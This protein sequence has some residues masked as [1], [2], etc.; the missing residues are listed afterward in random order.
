MVVM[1]DNTH[2]I[3]PHNIF[4]CVNPL[5]F[6]VAGYDSLN[7]K[8]SLLIRDFQPEV[9]VHVKNE[10]KHFNDAHME[11]L[12]G[13]FN[14]HGVKV[15]DCE[16]VHRRLFYGGKTAAFFKI[17]VKCGFH[18]IKYIDKQPPF[19]CS[20]VH[21][22]IDEK[23][24]LV[25]KQGIS[26]CDW[27]SYDPDYT[28]VRNGIHFSVVPHATLSK[29][30]ADHP[31]REIEI[32]HTMLMFD[33]ESEDLQK[34]K[35]DDDDDDVDDDEGGRDAETED[36]IFQISC[37]LQRGG[38]VLE[39]AIFSVYP[40]K[41]H[42]V[43]DASLEINNPLVVC[44]KTVKEMLTCFFNYIRMRDPDIIGGYNVI[45]FDWKR[46]L[47]TAMEKKM[48]SKYWL[49]ASSRSASFRGSIGK[50][51]NRLV[52]REWSSSASS[53]MHFF[54]VEME[55]RA[56]LDVL[57]FVKRN[58]DS[59]PSHKL[60]TVTKH[61]LPESCG[62]LDVEYKEIKYV[63]MVHRMIYREKRAK[64]PF[65]VTRRTVLTTIQRYYSFRLIRQMTDALMDKT[66]TY[67]SFD[68]VLEKVASEV[69]KYCIVDSILCQ[70]LIDK[71]DV[72]GFS[73]Q[74]SNISNIPLEDVTTRGQQ[75]RIMSMLYQFMTEAGFVANKP[76]GIFE[77]HNTSLKGKVMGALVLDPDK[78]YHQGVSTL[79]FE[80]LYPNIIRWF[81]LCHSTA[82]E[83]ATAT[84]RTFVVPEGT[85]YFETN[86]MGILPKLVDKMIKER[87]AVK[88]QL[89]T[90]P[91][92]SFQYRLLN[93]TQLAMKIIANSAY[94]FTA[95]PTGPRPMAP[96]AVCVTYM[97]R[98]NLKFTKNALEQRGCKVIYGDT[99][100]CM[101][102]PPT[103][104]DNPYVSHSTIDNIKRLQKR[105]P[106][107]TVKDDV[108][109]CADKDF[110][111]ILRQE[112]ELCPTGDGY[113]NVTLAVA[114]RITDF[115][116]RVAAE[117]TEELNAVE[118]TSFNLVHEV[119]NEHFFLQG[120]KYYV[121]RGYGSRELKMKGVMAVRRVYSNVEKAIF[122][123]VIT[124][125]FDGEDPLTAF[126]DQCRRVFESYPC[127]QI[128]CTCGSEYPVGDYVITCS[129][130]S[131]KDYAVNVLSDV[132]LD[133][134][135]NTFTLNK[136]TEHRLH[137]DKLPINASLAQD[138]IKRGE[139]TPD[140][141]RIEYLFWEQW[142]D[143]AVM[144]TKKSDKAM[145]YAA[146][147]QWRQSLRVR[148]IEYIKRTT[149]P[150]QKVFD[151]AKVFNEGEGS[152][153]PVRL[154]MILAN[155]FNIV[156]PPVNTLVSIKESLKDADTDKQKYRVL[157]RSER[158]SVVQAANITIA[159]LMGAESSW[160]LA[161][162][163]ADP[164]KLSMYV[165]TDLDRFIRKVHRE[166]A[167]KILKTR[168][169]SINDEYDKTL[170]SLCASL[171]SYII[172]HRLCTKRQK[173]VSTVRIGRVLAKHL[174][175]ADDHIKTNDIS[176]F[177]KN[178][179]IQDDMVSLGRC[180]LV[181]KRCKLTPSFTT[182]DG[183][184]PG[185]CD[186]I[187]N[188]FEK[189]NTLIS[190]MSAEIAILKNNLKTVCLSGHFNL[191]CPLT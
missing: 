83:V 44:C 33:I 16:L 61:Y 63:S 172:L 41:A 147:F 155:K 89:M 134:E 21:D 94:G 101:M 185:L 129:F 162:A 43:E 161:L 22:D 1:D 149:G 163:E 15:A 112:F 50:Y 60:K 177:V 39:Q 6:I 20:W 108:L 69:A 76:S 176:N 140:N 148:K 187:A 170:R 124:S 58:G 28:E 54:Y 65:E 74:V 79:D 158:D 10:E 106:H 36:N 47:T 80:S 48:D 49:T 86:E 18:K 51:E 110:E 95:A 174:N 146:F 35:V 84:T 125:M 96:V 131:M 23:L 138:I 12:V 135:G 115:S 17:L 126:T 152:Y 4:K 42:L 136:A 56:N 123:N 62:K 72:L 117:V 8:H 34:D 169:S 5:R 70:K 9:Y 7:R 133:A 191:K 45:Q 14:A 165:S 59:L 175:I 159:D 153:S 24:Q 38:K 67:E 183:R 13:F 142:I 30:A 66:S 122:T 57:E 31:V 188:V 141:T 19:P 64:T 11:E 189:R 186:S 164:R 71:L 78:S 103:S 178:A 118:S 92:D 25:T 144:C 179:E 53:K 93:A 98:Q 143:S 145:D 184:T 26:F 99:D 120:K 167:I 181:A 68:L 116:V 107:A 102:I 2:K 190:T 46:I 132:Y 40:I 127:A 130:K 88:Q 119:S 105:F 55:G 3:L 156:F 151:I 73:Q 75:H 37:H 114:K 160:K 82:R 113:I 154:A 52:D 29:V 104:M 128:D 166:V 77:Y 100:S 137:F 168:A 182:F 121:T 171:N 32:H 173:S 150:I 111:T 157:S 27:F 91:K 85:F 180:F 90:C 109:W 139:N 87:Q 97:G 81:N